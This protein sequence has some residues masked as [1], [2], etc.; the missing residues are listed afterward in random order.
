[1]EFFIAVVLL[2]LIPAAIA[3]SKGHNFF[4]WWF[5]GSALWI[6]ALVHSILLRRNAREL[7]DRAITQ[8]DQRKCPH[9]AEIIKSEAKVC[10]FCGRDVEPVLLGQAPENAPNWYS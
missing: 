5:Y 6:I 8:G 1:M 9:C 2:G 4:A 10:R 3:H 7:E